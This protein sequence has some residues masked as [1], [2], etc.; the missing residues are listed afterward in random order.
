M[1]LQATES[2]QKAKPSPQKGSISALHMAPCWSMPPDIPWERVFSINS[3]MQVTRNCIIINLGPL[4]TRDWEPVTIT[5]Q[6]LS[7]VKKKG[8]SPSLLHTPLEGPTEWVC[9]CKT[10]AKST[11]I[12]MWHRMEHVS[13]SPEFFFKYYRLDVGLRASAPLLWI[14]HSPNGW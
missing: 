14:H 5:L 8:A 3:S 6:A 9:E 2:L 7:L 4:H 12:P 1:L 11:C 10:D 13:W